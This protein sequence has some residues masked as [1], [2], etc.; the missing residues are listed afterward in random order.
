MTVKDEIKAHLASLPEA[1]RAGL[2]AL[3][4]LMRKTMPKAR[5][6]FVDGKDASGKTVMNPNIGYGQFTIEYANGTTKAFYP[7]GISANA[8]GYSVFIMGWKD[9]TRLPRTYG[10]TIGKA[11]VTGYCIKFKKLEDIDLKVLDAAVRERVAKE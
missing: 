9:K 7:V 11:K 3:D 5:L 1:K 8:S 2:A 4:R 6:W 10:K